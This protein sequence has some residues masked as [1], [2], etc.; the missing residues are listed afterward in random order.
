[1]TK[2]N[3]YEND[4]EPDDAGSAVY[5]DYGKRV[6]TRG[7]T[8]LNSDELVPVTHHSD[9]SCTIHCDG[10]CGPLYVDEFGNT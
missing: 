10:P 6:G 1:M 9:G 2:R 3:Y 7:Y 8:K 5:D 4:S